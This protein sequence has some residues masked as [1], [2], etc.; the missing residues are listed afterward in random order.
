M[1]STN[2]NWEKA[3]DDHKHCQFKDF[4]ER[5]FLPVCIQWH[6]IAT[7]QSIFSYPNLAWFKV[8]AGIPMRTKTLCTHSPLE[9]NHFN[10]L[11][12]IFEGWDNLCS[13]QYAK[14][15]ETKHLALGEHSISKSN[16]GMGI[17][18]ILKIERNLSTKYGLRYSYNRHSYKQCCIFY[19][20]C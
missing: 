1:R 8:V 19:E 11:H 14:H 15:N 4:Q 7:K 17:T 13:K 2:S 18:K 16:I 20:K 3:A 9:Q 6:S 12:V 5:Q 10:C